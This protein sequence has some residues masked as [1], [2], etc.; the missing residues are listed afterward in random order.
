MKKLVTLGGGFLAMIALASS[1]HAATQ[2][3]TA[4]VSATVPSRADVTLSRDTNST[5]RGSAGQLVFDK[6]DDKDVSEGST[7]FMYAPYRS[8]TGKNWHVAQIAANGSSLTL[9][10]T[11]TGTV[12]AASVADRLKIW[13]G[14][15]W[16]ATQGAAVVSGTTSSDWESLA[17]SGF[18]RSLSQSFNGTV[19]FSYQLDVTGISSG[20]YNGTVTFTLTSN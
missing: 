6:Y 9:T 15:F 13:C 20:S 2:S 3:S 17:G 19:P 12:G 8:E 18:S 11:A 1:A 14:G 16:P 5:S 7:G 4:S 10:V